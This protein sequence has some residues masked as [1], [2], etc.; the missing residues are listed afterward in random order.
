MYLDEPTVAVDAKAEYELFR[1]F[2]NLTKNK[3]TI[4]ISHRFSTVRMANKIIVMDKGKVAEQGEHR[5]LLARRGIYSKMFRLQA[6]G[7]KDNFQKKNQ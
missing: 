1:K 5:A 2:E 3:S 4:L 6:E 7:Y